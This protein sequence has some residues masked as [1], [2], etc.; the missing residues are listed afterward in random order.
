MKAQDFGVVASSFRFC[1][2]TLSGFL[3]V[4]L[5][6]GALILWSKGG[7]TA[8]DIAA[9]GA[10]SLRIA[11][12][13]GWVSFVMMAIYSNIGEAEDGMQTLATSRRIVDRRDAKALSA[14]KRRDCIRFSFIQLR[15]SERRFGRRQ[16]ECETR[17]A[18][19]D[20]GRIWRWKNRRWRHFFFVSTS[21]NREGS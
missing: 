17:R 19:R 20:R 4:V 15:P 8:G 9:T 13:S 1:L 5:V 21:P 3:P 10:V 14:C 11:Q 12:M 6:G 7:A 16:P 18:R 2:M